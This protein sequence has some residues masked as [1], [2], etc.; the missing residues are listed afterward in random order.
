MIE[1][2]WDGIAAYCHPDNKVALGFIE[3]LNNSKRWRNHVTTTTTTSG[4]RSCKRVLAITVGLCQFFEAAA[5][6]R[7]DFT[8]QGRRASRSLAVLAKGSCS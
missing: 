1:R 8:F 6:L 7:S 2:H 3:G 5:A 4:K